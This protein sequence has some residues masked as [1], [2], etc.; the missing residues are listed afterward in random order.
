VSL[1]VPHSSLKDECGIGCDPLTV[2]AVL[3]TDVPACKAQLVLVS[4]AYGEVPFTGLV[5]EIGL[6]VDDPFRHRECDDIGSSHGPALHSANP[7]EGRFHP[8]EAYL[9]T[10]TP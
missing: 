7:P 4:F 5:K 6:S 8:C 3:R 9:R 1:D 10:T 2:R